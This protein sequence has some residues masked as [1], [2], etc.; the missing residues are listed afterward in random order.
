MDT[1]RPHQH[2]PSTSHAACPGQEGDRTT[3]VF[4]SISKHKADA[5]RKKQISE[6]FW[7]S[8]PTAGTHHSSLMMEGG[9]PEAAGRCCCP[10]GG[11]RT[12]R[13]G[14]LGNT[15]Q[16]CKISDLNSNTSSI[17]SAF[18][19]YHG[20]PLLQSNTRNV[21]NFSF[22][23]MHWLQTSCVQTPRHAHQKLICQVY[24]WKGTQPPLKDS[25]V[26]L[27]HNSQ[28]PT[29]IYSKQP[30]PLLPAL[31]PEVVPHQPGKSQQKAATADTDLKCDFYK[32]ARKQHSRIATFHFTAPGR[33]MSA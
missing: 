6:L 3:F 5:S 13:A 33:K 23:G 15:Q 20:S 26:I 17:P 18:Y 16:P 30:L 2:T 24:R 22:K 1:A 9:L 25:Q 8:N 28:L 14:C 4:S 19:S 21:F 12:L 32:P 31:L 7:E 11:H 29:R 27:P 10:D